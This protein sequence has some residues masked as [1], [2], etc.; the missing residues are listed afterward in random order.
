[1]R[2]RIRT[3]TVAATLLL[4]ACG[5]VRSTEP[6]AGA[7]AG[8]ETA[9]SRPAASPVPSDTA[10]APSDGARDAPPDLVVT[11]DAATSRRR[12]Y[13][14]CWSGSGVGLCVDGR[15]TA[16]D[17]VDVRGPL[18]LSLPLDDWTLTATRWADLEHPEGPRVPLRPTGAGDWIVAERLP[19]GR[20]LLGVAGRGPEGDAFWVVPITVLAGR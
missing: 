7:T 5:G 14:Y 15:P 11:S 13:T 12:P 3:L 18:R 2:A 10:S 16:D 17:R 6:S 8:S 9:P 20:H 19:A 4:V 1:V